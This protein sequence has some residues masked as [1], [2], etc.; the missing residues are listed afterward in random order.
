MPPVMKRVL[1]CKGS[2]K[3]EKTLQVEP[4]NQLL[5]TDGIGGFRC[6]N[7]DEHVLKYKTG[8]CAGGACEGSAKKAPSGRPMPTCKWWKRCPCECHKIF[9]MMFAASGMERQ[10]QDNS[11]YKVDHS[12][13]RMPTPEERLAMIASSVGTGPTTP[14]VIESPAPDLVPATIRR[15]F[16]PTATGRA[17]RG[18]LASWVKHECDVW[19]VEELIYKCTPPYLAEAIAK[20]QGFAKPPSVGAV[21]A[22]LKR[23]VEIGFAVVEKKPTRFIKYT[24]DGIRLGLEGCI[25]RAK[26]TRRLQEAEA[27]RSF[28]R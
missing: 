4:C 21:D 1:T 7:R 5:V 17:A 23:W 22:V 16:T 8:F 12:L 25:E 18:E 3:N 20:T 27:G 26:R 9:D 2:V 11:G 13:F 28:R 10:L 15:V 24:D 14:I 6:K 19:L